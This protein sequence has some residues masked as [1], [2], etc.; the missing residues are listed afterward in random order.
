MTSILQKFAN[1]LDGLVL[2]KTQPWWAWPYSC[3]PGQRYAR[4]RRC[5]FL[6]KVPMNNSGCLVFGLAENAA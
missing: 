2:T 3:S 6:L 1:A 5:W 4:L